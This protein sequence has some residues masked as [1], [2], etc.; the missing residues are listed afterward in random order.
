MLK[1]LIWIKLIELLRQYSYKSL[2]E[3]K[4]IIIHLENK[5]YT[6]KIKEKQLPIIWDE[7]GKIIAYTSEQPVYF[8]PSVE[9]KRLLT[10]DNFAFVLHQLDHDSYENTICVLL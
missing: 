2:E 7:N 8:Q 3:Y 6:T 1:N 4:Q 10:F 5:K 9:S